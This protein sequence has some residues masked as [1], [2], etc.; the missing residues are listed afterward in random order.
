VRAAY[1]A[2]ILG[3]IG[4]LVLAAGVLSGRGDVSATTVAGVLALDRPGVDPDRRRAQA[5]A[6]L[7]ARCMTG[8]GFVW[9]PWV[10]PPPA[11]PDA[12]LDPVAW[13][14]RWGFGVSTT[15]GLPEPSAASDP[16]LVALAALRPTVVDGRDGYRDALDGPHGCR[17]A[18]TEAVYGLRERALAPIRASLLDLDAQ[19]AASPA[20]E[21]AT[22]A[23]RECVE[24]VAGGHAL[25]RR[26]LPFELR[27]RSVR[28][29]ADLSRM[30]GLMALQVEER[31]VAM[32]LAGCDAAYEHARAEAAAP[33]EA[34]FV[35]EHRAALAAIGAGI[36][37]AEAALPT[38]PP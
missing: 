35:S 34:A 20:A 27:D 17:T 19:I 1:T 18:E 37:A 10:E 33:I 15:V 28:Q 25:D 8:R 14:S 13:A 11:F 22:D 7:V 2:L 30:A 29:L 36:R 3:I 24:P 4:G 9:T 16:N 26:T 31:R 32:V 38:L 12:E 6:I 21:R 5:V 23:W